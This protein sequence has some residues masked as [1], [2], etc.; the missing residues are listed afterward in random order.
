MLDAPKY[1]EIAH[2]MSIEIR[3][4]PPISAPHKERKHKSTKRV[5]SAPAREQ[6]TKEDGDVSENYQEDR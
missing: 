1:H 2:D 5:S 6:N 4:L 3:P